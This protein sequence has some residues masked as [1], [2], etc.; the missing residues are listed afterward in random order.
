MKSL[1]LLVT[2]CDPAI[3]G[4]IVRLSGRA[5]FIH[6]A[7]LCLIASIISLHLCTLGSP[8]ILLGR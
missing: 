8:Y 6:S 5:I 4:L 3:I 7:G 2:L 1:N